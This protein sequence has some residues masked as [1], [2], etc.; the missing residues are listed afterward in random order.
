MSTLVA[1]YMRLHNEMV[2]LDDAGDYHL[3]DATRDDIIRRRMRSAW[4]RLSGQGMRAME[5]KPNMQKRYGQW[6]TRFRN[7]LY[8]S[9]TFNGAV[10]DAKA[11]S[12]LPPQ[13]AV[14]NVDSYIY[15][16]DHMGRLI[17]VWK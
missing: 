8:M 3:A 10:L 15:V 13:K 11:C 5:R 1:E 14:S 17:T 12:K 7:R 6:W 16:T 4:L 2:A 9:D